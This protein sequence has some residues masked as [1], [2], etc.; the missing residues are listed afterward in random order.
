MEVC[1]YGNLFSVI[2]KMPDYHFPEEQSKFYMACVVEA[3][4]YLH[5]KKIAYRDLKLENL[6]LDK[7]RYLKLTDFGISKIMESENS[8][9]STF[10]GTSA[11]MAPEM[12]KRKGHNH[13][14]DQWTAGILMFEML[15]GK[16]PF[17][18][19]PSL[20]NSRDIKRLFRERRVPHLSLKDKMKAIKLIKG[21]L[22]HN[23]YERI[24]ANNFDEIRG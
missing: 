2:R 16:P 18:D 22:K 11:Y 13:L 5:K 4:D 23:P 17:G 10:C 3:L 24:G 9:L 8:I 1:E 6:V 21:L 19:N 14:V 7:Y 12:V 15:S 20:L